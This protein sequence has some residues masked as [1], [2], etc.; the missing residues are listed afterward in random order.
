MDD[1]LTTE[2]PPRRLAGTDSQGTPQT[3]PAPGRPGSLPFT[4]YGGTTA[5]YRP[6]ADSPAKARAPKTFKCPL[7]RA[8]GF[9]TRSDLEG[10]TRSAHPAA[11]GAAAGD[12]AV[13]G[14]DPPD[15]A[16]PAP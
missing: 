3:R 5:P 9:A 16:G 11:G 1:H 15:A 12:A 13:P 7:C 14:G 10:H 6:K 2:D 8:S 4:P